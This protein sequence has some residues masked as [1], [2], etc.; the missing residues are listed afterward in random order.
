MPSLVADFINRFRS[1]SGPMVTA[2]KGE[3]AAVDCNLILP[4]Y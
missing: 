2:L 4:K 3:G 1:F